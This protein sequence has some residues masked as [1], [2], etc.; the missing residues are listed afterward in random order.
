LYLFFDKILR[1]QEGKMVNDSKSSKD[2]EIATFRFGII[3]DFVVGVRLN[4]GDKERLLKEK[5][6]K[7]YII[8]YSA[9]SRVSK[10]TIKKWILDYRS[11]GN[12]IEGLLPKVRKDSGKFRSLDTSIQMA[13]REIKHEKPD[14][15]GISLVTEL[16]HRKYLALDEKINLSVLYRFLKKEKLERP[17]KLIDRRAFEATAPNELWQSDILHGPQ[18]NYKGKKRKT[19]LIAIVDDHSRLIPHAEF[20]FSEMLENFKSC[21][22]EAITKRG[23]PQKLYIDNGSCYRAINLEQITASLGIGIV[24]TPPYTPQGRGKIERWFR[25]VRESFLSVNKDTDS[26]EKLNEAFDDWLQGYHNKVHSTTGETPLDRYKKNMK[27]V[28]PAPKDLMNYFRMVQF[29]TVKKDRTI[30]LNGT[31]FEVPVELIDYKIETRYHS[32]SPHEV[33]VYFDGRSH[34]M[35][36]LLDKSVNFKIARNHKIS[37]ESKNENIES[38]KLFD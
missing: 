36:I 1:N 9:Q 13:I 29:R 37:S 25:Y 18:V 7:K 34:G 3:S 19:Y 26:I 32:E 27:C 11:A 30:R 12:R 2:M 17:K 35:A 24:H 16:Q 38:G 6:G 10:S 23:L 4:Y 22:K 31:L 5:A 15:T 28:R 8:P 20:Y 14:L 33:E 21:L